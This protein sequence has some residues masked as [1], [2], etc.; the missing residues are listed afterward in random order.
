[1]LI[2]LLINFGGN[3]L[4]QYEVKLLSAAY[5]N[6][7]DSYSYIKNTLY[8]PIA[9]GNSLAKLEKAILSLSYF[10]YKDSMRKTGA[11]ANKGTLLPSCPKDL[12]IFK[13]IIAFYNAKVYNEP[14]VDAQFSVLPTAR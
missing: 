11:Y 2:P 8:S 4:E 10:P 6:L 14:I 9:A 12:L 1:M 7:E 3:I 13:R 5:N